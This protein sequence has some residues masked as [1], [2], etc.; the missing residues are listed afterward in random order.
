MKITSIQDQAQNAFYK[1]QINL[2]DSSKF[3]EIIL[4]KINVSSNLHLC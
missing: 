1:Y 2:S 3:M 4:Q